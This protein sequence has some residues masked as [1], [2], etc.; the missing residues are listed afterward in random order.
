[1][2]AELF[3]NLKRI[4]VPEFWSDESPAKRPF[5]AEFAGSTWTCFTD[6]HL[7][8][9][10]RGAHEGVEPYTGKHAGSLE[11]VYRLFYPSQS[12]GEWHVA[13][14]DELRAWVDVSAVGKCPVCLG[15]GLEPQELSDEEIER[16]VNGPAPPHFG[17]LFGRVVNRDTL[18]VPLAYLSA[19]EVRVF[20]YDGPGAKPLLFDAAGWMLMCM[21]VADKGEALD[22]FPAEEVQP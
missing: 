2:D 13:A 3:R 7:L 10:V 6:A 15:S 22:E 16:R 1:M 20:A 5:V 19:G 12:E 18:A 17:R 4:C 14:F 21:P 9:A 8:L 11:G